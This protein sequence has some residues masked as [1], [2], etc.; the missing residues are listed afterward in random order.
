MSDAAFEEQMNKFFD[1]T[2]GR[3]RMTCVSRDRIPENLR[4]G[5]KCQEWAGAACALQGL[6]LC[7][8]SRCMSVKTCCQW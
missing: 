8:R 6:Y 7:A 5:E 1:S 3:K 4:K 2:T